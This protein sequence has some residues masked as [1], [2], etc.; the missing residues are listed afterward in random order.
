MDKAN[1]AFTLNSKRYIM[2]NAVLIADG[3]ISDPEYCEYELAVFVA[4]LL[5]EKT[6]LMEENAEL[7]KDLMNELQRSKEDE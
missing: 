5:E 4:E 7:R 3:A 2:E 6:R 1:F